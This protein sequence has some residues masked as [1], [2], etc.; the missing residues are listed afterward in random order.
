MGTK[1]L[2][3]EK[4]TVYD[5]TKDAPNFD[6]PLVAYNFS[7]LKDNGFG[8]VF[9][10]QKE[11]IADGKNLEEVL[12]KLNLKETDVE[13]ELVERVYLNLTPQPVEIV[14]CQDGT[15]EINEIGVEGHLALA[16]NVPHA[17]EK[18]QKGMVSFRNGQKVEESDVKTV[19]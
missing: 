16:Y 1:G 4:I 10:S 6:C 8:D 2:K 13:V 18:I 17:W 3:S 5:Y 19:K 12:D 7:N 14:E 11:K 9:Y 15:A